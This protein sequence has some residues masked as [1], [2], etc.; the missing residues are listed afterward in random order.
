VIR[1]VDYDIATGVWPDM[2]EHGWA[3]D[4]WPMIF[5]KVHLRLAGGLG[6]PS[7]V[8]SNC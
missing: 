8:N 6:D 1:A 5:E 3:V 2:R 7:A 4:D